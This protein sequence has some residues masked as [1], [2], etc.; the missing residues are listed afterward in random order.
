MNSIVCEQV[1][2]G[3]GR[4][5]FIGLDN[6]W[7]DESLTDN[8]SS[9]LVQHLIAQ[10]L[11]ETTPGQ[12]EIITYDDTL[13]G[14]AAP[15]QDINNGGERLLRVIN[16]SSELLECLS[17]LRYH[18]QGVTNV[19]QGRAPTLTEF[20]HMIGYPI[21][22]YK[23]VVLST[24]FDLLDEE[25][26]NAVRTLAKAGPRNGV[27]FIIHSTSLGVNEFLL[28]L[29]QRISLSG[30]K[31]LDEYGE[32]LGSFFGTNADKLIDAA[33]SV[34]DQL[35]SAAVPVVP[36]DEIEPLKDGWTHSS[37]DGITFS[38]GRYGMSPITITLGDEINQRHNALVTGAVGQGK[39]NL[40]SVIVHSLCHRYSPDELEF[41][42]LDF[43]EGVTL[44]RFTDGPQGEYLPHAR[45]LGLEADREFGLAVFKHL[46]EVYSSRMKQFKQAGVQSLREYRMQLPNSRMPRVVLIVD[47]FQMMFSERDKLSDQIA[48]L[49]QKG[50]RLFRACGIHVVLASQTIGGNNSLMGSAAEGL[51]GQVPIRIALKNSLSE[52]QATLGARNDAAAHLRSREAIVNLDYG[53]ISA[54]KKT[55]IAF[56]DEAI[57]EPL[58]R[59][60]WNG[61]RCAPPPYV[62]DGETPLS[63]FSD[64]TA[65]AHYS[66]RGE[67][68]AVAFL[69]HRIDVDGSI[70][71]V[72]MNHEVGRN[73]AIIGPANAAIPLANAVRSLSMQHRPGAAEVVVLDLLNA[74]AQWEATRTKLYSDLE[75]SGIPYRV[76]KYQDIEATIDELVERAN[77]SFS[78]LRSDPTTYLL[79]LGLERL[80]S[81]GQ[82]A[83]LCRTGAANSIHI[84]G[85]WMKADMFGQHVG[86]GGSAYFDIKAAYGLDRQTTRNF[87]DEPL[88]EWRPKTNR[89][90]IWDAASMSAPARL[91]PYTV[92]PGVESPQDH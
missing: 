41:Y 6:I 88:L 74:N 71:S 85:W 46:F 52:S 60:W 38:V 21:E 78:L 17:F 92:Y 87:L 23:L 86:F 37:R 35:I 13:S 61:G 59:R 22:G 56:A 24:D 20:R 2:F 57:L 40:I 89:M 45:V 44:Q 68:S 31:V 30:D 29:F 50:V 16:E 82:F 42:L 66:E 39:S 70:F 1:D 5:D 9:K 14:L 8:S 80:H 63:L 49:L 83:E 77:G 55:A 19:I 32:T 7:I 51:F 64:Q 43:K 73:I 76:I 28:G 67:G 15:F 12:L 81:P 69:G 36:F 33:R 79:G 25:I 58:R 53:A 72:P 26:Q 10:A 90:I 11:L 47:E 3:A 18:V 75:A 91:I 84:L 65:L 48:D 54:N 4:I 34:K 27:S 62:F